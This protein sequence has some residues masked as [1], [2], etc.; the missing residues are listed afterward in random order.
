MGKPISSDALLQS[1]IWERQPHPQATASTRPTKPNHASIIFTTWASARSFASK[2]RTIPTVMN[3]P[4][5]QRQA[6]QSQDRPGNRGCGGS[7]NPS[8]LPFNEQRRTQFTGKHARFAGE[9]LARSDHQRCFEIF[10]HRRRGVSLFRR[11]RP[12]RNRGRL[13]PD[14]YEHWPVDQAIDEMRRYGHNWPKFSH[15]GGVS[16]WQEDHL[17][18]IAK[19]IESDATSRPDN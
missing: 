19:L 14:Q 11:T 13:H 4:A 16:S 6:T 15:N 12:H 1:G 8:G 7:G 17:R 9:S 2:T 18:A 10:P 3:P 5:R